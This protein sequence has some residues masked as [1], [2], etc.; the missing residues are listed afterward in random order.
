MFYPPCGAVHGFNNLKQEDAKTLAVITPAL[1][2]TNYFKEMAS[3]LN[4]GGFSDVEKLKQVMAKHGL[5]P[6][7][8]KVQNKE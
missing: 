1:L 2:G 5:V 3:I 8:P 4:A 7:M 6:A